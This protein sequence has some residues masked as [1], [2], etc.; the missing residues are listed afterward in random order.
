MTTITTIGYGDIISK[1]IIE[2]IFEIISLIVGTCLYSL[3]IT[4]ASNY[5][6]KM[7][8]KYLKFEKNKKILDE[9][10]INYPLM[11]ECLYDRI[12]RLLYYKKYHEETD[13]NIIFESL[14]FS[15]R[16]ELITLNINLIKNYLKI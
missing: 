7:N 4:S 1:S 15:I 3:I 10:K 2:I 9:I 8:E 5:I 14:P 11:N 12:Y 13:N 6:K 16:N